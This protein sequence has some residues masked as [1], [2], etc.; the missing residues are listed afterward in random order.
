MRWFADDYTPEM[1]RWGRPSEYAWLHSV[2]GPQY[3]YQ[4]LA[5]LEWENP[6][7]HQLVLKELSRER[8]KDKAHTTDAKASAG[9]AG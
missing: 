6:A 7:L 9:K 3:Q 8:L 4:L 5:W 2:S 1:T